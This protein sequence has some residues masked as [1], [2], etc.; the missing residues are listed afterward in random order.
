MLRSFHLHGKSFI[1][2]FPYNLK[3]SEHFVDSLP[4]DLAFTLVITS[5]LTG[6]S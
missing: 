5:F 6:A 3:L 1:F 4:V 2:L